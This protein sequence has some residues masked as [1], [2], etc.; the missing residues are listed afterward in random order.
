MATAKMAEDHGG[1]NGKSRRRNAKSWN[2]NSC[3]GCYF[4]EGAHK[5]DD[6][7]NRAEATDTAPGSGPKRGAFAGSLRGSLGVGL[8]ARV[9]SGSALIT[10]DAIKRPP[11]P[12][13]S[14]FWANDSG[15]TE[16][17]TQDPTGLEDYT[18]APAGDRVESAGGAL[19][20]V[21]GYGHL[22][23]LVD[24]GDDHF[25]DSTRQFKLKHV[26]HVPNL[27]Q[28]NL[29][30]TKR[31]AQSFDAPMRI[32]PAAAVIHPRRGGKPLRFRPLRPENGLLEIRARRH[33]PAKSGLVRPPAALAATHR[34]QRDIIEFH[35]VL[36]HPAEQITRDTARMMGVQ[37][38]GSW[39]PCVHCSESRVCRYAVPKSTENRADRRAGRLF[40]DLSGPFHETS[41]GGNRFVL[42]CVDDYTRFKIICFLKRKSEAANAFRD[43]IHD[44]FVPEGLKIGVVRTDGGGEWHGQFLSVLSEL[45]IKRESTPP[46]TPQYNGVVERALGLLRD[47]TVALLRGVIEGKSDRLWAEAMAYACD[48]WN[49]CTTSSLDSGTSPYELWYGR[50]PTFDNILPFG[51]VR[52]LRRPR[53]KHKLAPR[54]AKCIMLGLAPGCP[55][56]TF[57]VRDLNTGRIDNRQ[58]VSWH[59]P[60]EGQEVTSLSAPSRHTQRRLPARRT[61]NTGFTP[62]SSTLEVVLEEPEEEMPDSRPRD[63]LS[64][65]SEPADDASEP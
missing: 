33:V 42:L 5:S 50:R 10:S 29:L 12:R 8:Y 7:P 54:G 48:M 30:S 4:C 15:A 3:P 14:E 51:T 49:R 17:M 20:P 32:Y 26:A 6:C 23:L 60:T 46:Y 59:P 47:K 16:H 19:L 11:E 37:L 40:I 45:G 28:H 21:A 41:L 62:T 24:R 13:G 53:P 65:R 38:S 43:I 61:M 1:G 55:R 2:K 52:Y 56:D 36:G 44:Y 27:G 18:P 63:D 22:R 31:L 35:Q 39:R 25:T 64:E 34:H 57:R 58:A 9:S